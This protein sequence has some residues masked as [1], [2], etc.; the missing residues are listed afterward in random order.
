[1]DPNSNQREE[2]KSIVG[3]DDVRVTAV[4]SAKEAQTAFMD[5][6]IDCVISGPAAA[7]AP[8]SEL[9]DQFAGNGNMISIPWIVYSS[10][11]L[12]AAAAENLRRLAQRVPVRHVKSPER[13]IDQ[14]AMFLHRDVRKIESK[15][16][17]VLEKLHD[18]AQVLANKK[19]LIVDDDIRN[20]FALTSVLERQNMSIYSAE[21]GLDAIETLKAAPDIDIVLMD[22]MMPEMDGLDTT[23]AI[24]S[25]PAFRNLPIVAVTAKAMKGDR[26]KCIEA[27]AWDYLAKPV[28]TE[29]MLSVMKAWLHR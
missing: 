8:L 5:N 20:I 9:A 11:E 16:R 18:P 4:S 14:T 26:E 17:T 2:I 12:P 13:L 3:S 23:R 6:L 25:I 15:H 22:I 24:R 19:V 1:L 7:E 27:G 21:T 29:Q 28:D 10:A